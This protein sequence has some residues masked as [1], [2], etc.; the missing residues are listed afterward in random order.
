MAQWCAYGASAASEFFGLELCQLELCVLYVYNV[1]GCSGY[2]GHN[3]CGS[4]RNI[5]LVLR[6]GDT[7]DSSY[8]HYRTRSIVMILVNTSLHQTTSHD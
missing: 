2:P 1:E 7:C 8:Q 4:K 5:I 3:S 6:Y